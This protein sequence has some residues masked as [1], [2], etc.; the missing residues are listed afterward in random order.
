VFTSLQFF[1]TFLG[2]AAGGYLYGHNGT[3]GIVIF[4]AGLLV[5]WLMVALAPHG[6]QPAR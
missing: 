4:N 2:A 3:A 5:I 6:G 1:G